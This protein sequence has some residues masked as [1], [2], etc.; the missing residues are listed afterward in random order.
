MHHCLTVNIVTLKLVLTTL[1]ISSTRN[2]V[3]FHCLIYGLYTYIL[4][5]H[6]TGTK[7]IFGVYPLHRHAGVWG[8]DAEVCIVVV[9]RVQ[10]GC[11]SYNTDGILM[12]VY[13]DRGS[14]KGTGV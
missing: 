9:T 10:R 8:D 7:V 3:I 2:T 13:D 11:Q 4:S 5:F 6:Y 12:S 14:T 1:L